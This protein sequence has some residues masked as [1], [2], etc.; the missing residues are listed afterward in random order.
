MKEIAALPGS[1]NALTVHLLPDSPVSSSLASS[2]HRPTITGYLIVMI[3][4]VGFGAWA[5]YAPLAGGAV[6]YGIVGPNS[7][8][9][10]IQHLEGG[11]VRELR[12]REGDKVVAG[13]TLIVLEPIQA[14]S[15]YD[16][17]L[18]QELA[19]LAKQARL[20]A[21][22]S[23][24]ASVIFP[25]ALHAGDSLLPFA[26]SQ[27]Q[28]FEARRQT[29]E[30]RKRLLEQRGRQLTEQI[31]GYKIQIESLNTQ[32]GY[33][34]EEVNA[35]QILLERGLVPKPEALRLKRAESE[36]SGRQAE[37]VTEIGKAEQQIGET[38]LQLLSAD[39]ERLEEITADSD[40]VRA[41]LAATKE[42]L[43]AS[44]D[45]LKRTTIAAPVDGTVINLRTK[46]LGGVVQR[47]EPL[48][49]IVP[50]KDALIV[51]ARV[52]PNDIH[53]VHPNQ[54]AQIHLSSYSFR[55]MPRIDG[56]V[57]A[58]SPDR[59]TDAGGYQ[60]YFLARVE[61]DRASLDAAHV[62]LMPGMPA[63]VIFVAEK[64][65]LLEYLLQ[66]FTRM[67]RQGMRES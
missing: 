4:V 17:L 54:P 3:F 55:V 67:T 15:N 39:A 10:T 30:A 23:G 66:P 19:S 51:E 57:R 48:M 65:T 29:H 8:R 11:I 42:Q 25:R 53:R 6:A 44:A 24:V 37:F 58:V 52:A 35:K 62:T 1:G 59:V 45:V 5:A 21:E 64:R 46:T 61:V 7:S 28:L 38:R 16:G 49:E 60:S 12:V 40:K 2:V 32:L 31:K 41:E 14:R 63:D 20:S 22:K 34:R 50:A 9:R 27:Q 47:G 13:Q 18:N 26:Q 56:V 43:R 36:L 33:I